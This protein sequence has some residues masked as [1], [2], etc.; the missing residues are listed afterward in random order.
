MAAE[1]TL[2]AMLSAHAGLAAL[3]GSGDAARIYPDALPEDCDYPAVV[4]SAS[5]EPE[6][7]IDDTYFGAMVTLEISS[8]GTT[9]ASASG[10][11]AQAVECLN[12]N[13]W[14]YSTGSS[15][16]DPDVGLFAST[17]SVTVFEPPA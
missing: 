11:M 1:S 9:R 2:Y 8:W 6:Y 4:Y 12:Q 10:V 16:F 3:V 17:I 14:P 5:R 13:G 15:P 7:G